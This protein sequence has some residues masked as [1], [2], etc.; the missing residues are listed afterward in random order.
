MIGYNIWLGRRGGGGVI[1]E[2][3]YITIQMPQAR[4][5]FKFEQK[6]KVYNRT[7]SM[8]LMLLLTINFHKTD[9]RGCR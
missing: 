4:L 6:K 7:C 8:Y 2:V 1:V 5:G 9:K 3:G